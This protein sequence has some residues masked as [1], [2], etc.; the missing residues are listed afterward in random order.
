MPPVE[1]FV[2]IFVV[3][4]RPLGFSF[5][6]LLLSGQQQAMKDS[7]LISK[8]NPCI[9]ISMKT[10]SM[11]K[12]QLLLSRWHCFWE[13]LPDFENLLLDF[14]HLSCSFRTIPLVF[15]SAHSVSIMHQVDYFYPSF[16][17][18]IFIVVIHSKKLCDFF[19]CFVF[20][21]PSLFRTKVFAFEIQCF[22]LF[23]F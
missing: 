9:L 12:V 11:T 21:L 16:R 3:G 18:K 10:I 17:K 8:N 14:S 13:S 7:M 15:N 19:K 20:R 22:F 23:F 2:R 6:L 1:V 5:L 4:W